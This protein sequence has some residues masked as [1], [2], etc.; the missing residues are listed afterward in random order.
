MTDAAG[1]AYTAADY[2]AAEAEPVIL[3]PQTVPNW[4]AP[5]F[6]WAVRQ[7]VAD[8]LCGA[9]VETCP[10]LE[11][12][13]LKII[14]T[15]DWRLQQIAEKWV[16]AAAI[17]PHTK[18]PKAYAK[19][20][21]VP[22]QSWMANLR[23]KDLHNGALVAIDYQTGQLVAYVGSADYYAT[24][25]SAKFQ[26][27]F[28]VVGD[29]W[30]QVGSAF[31]PFNYV[32]GI[33]DKTMTAA[34]M[35]MDV[36]TNFGTTA[37]PYIP[38]DADNLE[39]G[40][41][42]MREALEFS[43]NIPAVKAL[44]YNGVAHVATTGQAVRHGLQPERATGRPV[45]DAGHAGGPPGRLRDGLGDPRQPGPLHRPHDDPADRGAQRQR[46]RLAVQDA[47]RHAGGEPAGGLH[48]HRRP[49]RQHR[50]QDQPLL[51]RLQAD[52]DRRHATAG[53]AQ[54]GHQQRR[55]RP[56]RL[57]LH[58]PALDGRA[59]R[60]PVRARRRGLERQQR[61]LPGQHRQEPPVLHRR[62]RRSCGRAS[63]RRRPR[64][65]RSTSSSSRPAS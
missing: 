42:R 63:W 31:K 46:R 58:R 45:A 49:G 12:G 53:D 28:D 11:A 24:N 36:T 44:S 52:R 39:R 47:G 26:P 29:G 5:Q 13:G 55:P 6:V 8:E 57:R 60:R 30:R 34:T 4:K 1:K 37:A 14:T 3:A 19:Q 15:L 54:D 65:G 32:V 48:H 43:L 40:P 62:R 50:P 20:I 59:E 7:Q 23:N 9:G 25:A 64:P 51:G 16:K 21:G 33:N 38:T 18:D 22:Y 2:A 35:F 10:Q 27:Q 61:Q 56:E 17:L 41:V